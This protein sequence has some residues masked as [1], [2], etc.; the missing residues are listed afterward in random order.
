M[1][2]GIILRNEN[3]VP[4]FDTNNMSTWNFLSYM[5]A[6]AGQTVSW[7]VVGLNFFSEV[8]VFRSFLDYPLGDQESYIHE[9]TN[10]GSTFRATGG[11]VNTAIVVLAR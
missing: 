7:E 11:S 2:S 6:P 10:L 4:F 5:A 3:N 8:Q 1:T 9:V